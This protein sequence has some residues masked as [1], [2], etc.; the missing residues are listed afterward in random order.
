MPRK[1][2]WLK[3]PQKMW[4]DKA[5]EGVSMLRRG[6]IGGAFAGACEVFT[7]MSGG[8]GERGRG[9]AREGFMR[10]S[11]ASDERGRGFAREGFTRA[12]GGSGERGRINVPKWSK[13][14]CLCPSEDRDP[15]AELMHRASQGL[16]AE[17][18]IEHLCPGVG[19]GE[20]VCVYA[21]RR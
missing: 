19:R 18:V 10:A 15:R 16:R 17:A 14:A 11:G 12:S 21:K 9:F 20:R 3:L 5:C 2:G 6:E 4:P 8:S 1:I 7:R 13:R